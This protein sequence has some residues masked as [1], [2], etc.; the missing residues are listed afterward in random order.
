MAGKKT[1]SLRKPSPAADVANQRTLEGAMPP[2]AFFD[3]VRGILLHARRQS[4]AASNFI[5]VEAYWQIGHRIVQQ[6]QGGQARAEYGSHLIRDLARELGEEFGGGVSIANLKNFRQF[7]QTFPDGLKSYAAR[8]LSWTHWRLLMRVENIDAREYYIRESAEQGWNTR[9]LERNV[10]TLAFER[11]LST[12]PETVQIET[13]IEPKTRTPLDPL[14]F[15]K[16]PYVLEFLGLPDHAAPLEQ[17]LES[18]L[19]R[20]NVTA[21][22][23]P[24]SGEC[25]SAQLSRDGKKISNR[26]RASS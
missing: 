18:A 23:T 7:Y 24:S 21:T 20:Y 5:M 8:S 17:H 22:Q 6:E 26:S 4:Y 15:I 25:T 16:D 1:V 11:L 19:M 9:L 13:P 10:A 14:N 3:D 12:A 2:A